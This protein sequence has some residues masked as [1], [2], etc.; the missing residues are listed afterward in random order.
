[1]IAE[2]K[3]VYDYKIDK[4]KSQLVTAFKR[5][6]NESTIA[7]LI[8]TTGLPK[9]QVQEMTKIV[10]DEYQGHLKATESGELLYYFPHGMRSRVHGFVPTAKRVLKSILKT[11]GKILAFLFKIWIMLMLVGY[12]V[13][14]LLILI[15]AIILSVAASGRSNQRSRGRGGGAFFLVVRLLEF[16]LRIF[17]WVSL[18]KSMDPNY[19]KK[20]KGR[21][22]YKSIFAYVFGETDPTAEWE[23]QEKLAIISYIRTNKGIITLDELMVLTGKNYDGAQQL[24]NHYLLEFEGEPMVSDNGT[25]Y[26]FFPELLRSRAKELA[27]APAVYLSDIRYRELIPFATNKGSTNA[28]ITG[29]NIFNLAFGSYF[30]IFNFIGLS[31]AEN[32]GIGIFYIFIASIFEYAEIQPFPALPVFI[33]LGIIPLSFSIIFFLIPLLRTLPRLSK[34]EKIKQDNLRKKIYTYIYDNPLMI[35][36][37]QIQPQSKLD[38]PKKP[39]QFIQKQVDELAGIKHAEFEAKDDNVIFYNFDEIKREQDDIAAV[40]KSIDLKNYEIGETVFDS[41][42]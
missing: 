11:T 41:D 15:G 34:N 10:L 8:A 39:V 4:V 19:R 2:A 21:P 22:L 20:P 42:E 18:T 30:F 17:F 6:K 1:M 26:F 29:F 32:M 27:S 13:L 7:D 35:N 33:I 5:R 28:L 3:K 23:S 40:R 37:G 24:I 12:F 38:T 25:I 9:Y 31:A 36:P 14:F 16:F